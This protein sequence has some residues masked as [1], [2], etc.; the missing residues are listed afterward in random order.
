MKFPTAG[1]LIREYRRL[2][3]ISQSELGMGKIN[4]NT[5][6]KIENDRIQINPIMAL[7]ISDNINKLAASKNL[8]IKIN[9]ID[10]LTTDEKK[11]EKWCLDE[12]EIM[13]KS[14]KV[15]VD[16]CLE[17]L[18]S[19]SKYKQTATTLTV[20]EMLAD[21]YYSI[22]DQGQAVYYYNLCLGIYKQDNNI[23]K[24]IEINI[25]IGKCYYETNRHKAKEYY[26]KACE[27]AMQ[28]DAQEEAAAAV[29]EAVPQEAADDRIQS[30]IAE[31]TENMSG[32][33]LSTLKAR[34]IYN[35]A[36]Y[37]TDSKDYNS[38]KSYIDRL[39][40]IKFN[41]ENL[42]I[43]AMIL[44]GSIS[45]GCKD[46]ESA[47]SIF[48]ALLTDFES[49]VK[50]YKYIIYNN[51][52]ICLN[53]LGRSEKA[54]EYF[55]LAIKNQLEKNLPNLTQTLINAA[56]I[57]L[58]NNK[59]DIALRYINGALYNTTMHHQLEFAVKCYH[60]QYRIHKSKGALDQCDQVLKECTEFI[61]RNR[62][63]NELIYLTQL[64]LADF[65]LTKGQYE[66][67]KAMLN[68]S[69]TKQ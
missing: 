17:I 62:L 5:I 14:G 8:D 51:L 2:L 48:E 67:A 35:L 68:Q 11:C 50:Q 29:T 13:T 60:I 64:F 27:Y 7:I 49:G 63:S 53:H 21:Y 33:Q 32:E 19:A 15:D 25:N 45:V 10:L 47:S 46:Y 36:L 12:I 40:D 16:K 56:C 69:I 20:C 23:Q 54:I 28:A 26:E 41:N 58:D 37:H 52:A 55:D 24:I 34:V 38:A 57:N 43:L 4:I 1:K 6:C 59:P 22:K 66:E 42:Y 3:G 44:K 65:M 31:H 61:N 30:I 9:A 39:Q 18:E